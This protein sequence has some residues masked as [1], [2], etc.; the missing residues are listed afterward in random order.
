MF[1][2]R[3]DR[4]ACTEPF[5]GYGVAVTLGTDGPCALVA[6]YGDANR[7]LTHHNGRLRDVATPAVAD[8]D[9]HGL[10]ALAADLDGDGREELYVH[11]ADRFVGEC[12][13]ADLLLDP[14]GHYP[15]ERDGQWRDLF[16][17]SDN[18][19]R[20]NFRAG[21]SLAAIDRYGTGRYGVFVASYDDTSRFYEVGEDDQVSDMASEVGLDVRARACSTLAG[22]LVSDRTDLYLG[23]EDGP[24]RL[25][26]NE[27]GEF[28]EVATDAD[29]DATN[30][31]ARGVTVV[32]DRL[33]VGAWEGPNRL[34]APAVTDGGHQYR[35]SAPADFAAPSRVRTLVAADFDNDGH[36]E[37]F[38][39]A[40]G[41]ENRLFRAV[42][43]DGGPVSD[44]ADGEW[45]L[46][47]IDAGSAT[48]PRG[49][50]TGAAVADFD[51]DG[52]L[53]LLVVHGEIEPRPLSVYRAC[54]P[55]ERSLRIR[56]LTPQGAPARGAVVTLETDAWTRRKYVCAGSGYLCQMEPTAHFG[57]GDAQP[58]RLTVG[59]P[60]GR[61]TSHE[62]PA[63][64]TTR[65]FEHP[66]S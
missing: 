7:L 55:C 52:V 10:S 11:N 6:G 24:N 50:G 41:T 15:D 4:L 32:H 43:P 63:V 33:A 12:G 65:E 49:L 54:D 25:F 27:G 48:E 23:V 58:R 56:P 40:L 36:E 28:R 39:N 31:N 64:G 46:R 29:L 45:S 16:G 13:D 17:L 57:L 34:F 21:R 14:V 8:P 30:T 20:D 47:Q 26:H 66:S 59:W 62:P 44:D 37:L 3:P 22:P 35:D 38:V 1:E 60:D 19:D 18:V 61:E 53:E 2:N 5:R 42:G 51:G 9:R